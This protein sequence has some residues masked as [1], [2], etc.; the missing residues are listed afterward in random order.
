M[1]YIKTFENIVR[2]K[3]GDYVLLD[4]DEIIEHNKKIKNEDDIPFKFSK[5]INMNSY[6]ISFP[7]GVGYKPDEE[8][9]EP[10]FVRKEEI[11]RK[12]S[13]EEIDEYEAIKNSKK[14]NL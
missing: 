9:E 14:Y 4:M 13:P 8:D 5:I 10:C 6:L 11:I 7:Y 12:L 3:I 1:K 2:Y